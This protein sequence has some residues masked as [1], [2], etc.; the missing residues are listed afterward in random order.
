MS[1]PKLD[2][3]L[4][5]GNMSTISLFLLIFFGFFGCFFNIIIFTSKQLRKSSCAFYFLCTAMLELFI[6]FF[7]GISRL[8]TEHFG[9]TFINQNRSF[10]KIRSYLITSFGSIATYLLMMAAVDR[11]MSTS[12]HVRHRGFSQLKIAY[13]IVSVTSIVTFLINIHVLIFF[14]PQPTCI[15]QPGSYALFYSIYVIVWTSILPDGLILLFTLWTFQNV[16]KL[17]LRNATNVLPNTAQQ[18]SKQRVETQLVIVSD[19]SL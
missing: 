8:A 16:K 19:Y 7:G 9:S 2:L 1:A 14:N 18:R 11:Y 6:L 10:C 12:V 3:Q 13:R 5:T 15:P 4:A 17:R